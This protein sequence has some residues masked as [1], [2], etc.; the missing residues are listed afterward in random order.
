[1]VARAEAQVATTEATIPLLV[2]Q[3]RQLLHMLAVLLGEPPMTLA[4]ELASPGPIPKGP[5][6]VDVGIPSE[7]VQRRPDLRSSER[8][9]AAATA[10]IG[11]ATRDLYPRFFVTG[12]AAL[13]SIDAGTL[14][15]W[16][17]RA[18]SI[19]PTISWTVFDAGVIRA[20][21]ALRT[22]QQQEVLA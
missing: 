20:T 12:F 16:P 19:G 17:S 4:S 2:E 1:D 18:A 13:E 22:A 10:D 9:L 7:I 14:F 8:Q 21:I 5:A 6:M 3:Q 15:T 11:V